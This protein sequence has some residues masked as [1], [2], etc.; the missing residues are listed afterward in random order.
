MP[1]AIEMPPVKSKDSALC[2]LDLYI[3]SPPPKYPDNK[4]SSFLSTNLEKLITNG[5]LNIFDELAKET[6]GL[7]EKATVPGNVYNP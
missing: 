1:T 2:S 5:I 6:E 7:R 4:T 3:S